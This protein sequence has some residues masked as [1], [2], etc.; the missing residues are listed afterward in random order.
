MNQRLKCDMCLHGMVW[1]TLL[2]ALLVGMESQ[3]DA[4]SPSDPSIRVASPV[5]LNTV[6]YLPDSPK[7]ATS[8]VAN[9]PFEVR[10]VSDGQTVFTGKSTAAVLNKDTTEELSTIDFS[11]LRETGRY[12]IE[13]AGHDRSPE[14]EIAPDVF[15]RLFNTATKAMYLTRC[16]TAVSGDHDGKTFSHEACHLEDAHTDFIAE[17]NAQ[18]DAVGGW[19][20]AGDYNK[21]VVNAGITVGMLLQAWDH[22]D[23]RLRGV[24]LNIPE[25][26]NSIP[27]F[28]DEVR[29]EME[30]I[31]KTQLA[32]GSVSHKVTTKKFGDFLAP[33]KENTPR[34]F[35]PWSSAAT[36]DFVAMTAATAR[37]FA[38]WDP[39]F[40]EKCLEASKKS[41][42]F[43]VAHPDPQSA[44]YRDFS[45]GGYDSRDDDDRLWAAAELWE[46]TGDDIYLKDFEARVEKMMAA[47][48]RPIVDF[49]WD[50]GD[51][52][53]LA[54]FTY[55]M[56]TR[57]GRTE[58]V[59]ARVK[60]DI[61]QV[62]DE[63][64]DTA[65]NHGYARPLGNR[66]YWGCNGTVARMAMVLQVADML[67]LDPKYREA[68]IAALDHLLGRN[69]YGRSFVTG[70]GHRPPL[71]PH[72][73]RNGINGF[74]DPWP[75][76]LIGGAWPSARDWHDDPED[77]R[78]N[79][80]AINWNGA[81]IYAIA[82][83]VEPIPQ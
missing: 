70:I 7:R 19:H 10:R 51:V 24:D 68:R 83:F 57:P 47:S 33:E 37:V 49:N 35:T 66:Y 39:A 59:L 25:S 80:I 61:V 43:L 16:G 67:E 4:Q 36:A 12:A 72:D 73:R 46:A 44:R 20:D 18:S 52:S 63:V 48:D 69:Y 60:H 76:Y 41:Y 56:S 2:A 75:G 1:R 29:W 74:A 3:L 15:N 78:T 53:N 31:L 81:L 21:Y 13:I 42:D 23:D 82:G 64:V 14:F 34:Y 5:R 79:E 17:E 6:G 11:E 38:E 40:A 71:H 65:A 77:Y 9:M 8:T 50:W 32:D 45:T 26:N 27:D 30:W 62:A 58:T 28:L 55:V 54:M 22:Y